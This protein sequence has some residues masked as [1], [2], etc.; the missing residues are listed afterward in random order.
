MD[1]RVSTGNDPSSGAAGHF[2]MAARLLLIGYALVLP[3][4]GTATLQAV[5]LLTAMACLLW[6]RRNDFVEVGREALW[7]LGPL[8]LFSTWILLVCGFWPD[9]ALLSPEERTWSK[10]QPWFSLDQWRRDIGQPM[11]SL[12][13]GYQAFRGDRWKRALFL[14]QAAF[15]VVVAARCL[16]QFYIPEEV[17]GSP[18]LLWGTFQVRGFSRD[19]VFFSYVLLLLTPAALWLVA[20]GKSNWERTRD[21]VF[22][23]TLLFLI[24]LNKRRGTWLAVYAEL[25]LLV[26]WL[27]RRT[28]VVFLLATAL[29]LAG[30]W[31]AK[32]HWFTRD[33]DRDATGRIKIL[34]NLVSLAKERPLTGVGFGKDTVIKNYWA[35]IYQH[36][37]SVYGDLLL[38]VGFPG[39]GLWI[40]ALVLYGRRFWLACGEGWSPRVGLV[41]LVA[42]CI[43]NLT[44]DVWI[45]SNAELF[46]F[47]I[48]VFMADLRRP[49]A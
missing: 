2:M 40:L 27:G 8:L 25:A 38:E 23:L 35:Y 46:W 47:L 1:S 21:G 22:L 30:A 37:H 28:L 26:S 31:Q 29:L 44:D 16:E 48:G 45:A 12:L 9:P 33:Y 7:L 11:L 43:R 24:F 19:N 39:L 32:P 36:A 42:F 34:Q 49:G 6:N 18:I 10:Q 3:I 4:R 5:L 17:A 13:C 14:A 15:L 41:L 20:Q